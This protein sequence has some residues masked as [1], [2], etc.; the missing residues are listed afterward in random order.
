MLVEVY[1]YVGWCIYVICWCPQGGFVA[2]VTEMISI[3]AG[4]TV[5]AETIDA[6]INL[7]SAFKRKKN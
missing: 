5:V 1:W 6:P 3:F 7:N 2:L 4:C